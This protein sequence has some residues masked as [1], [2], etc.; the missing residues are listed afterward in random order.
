MAITNNFI[1]KWIK[2]VPNIESSLEERVKCYNNV[3]VMK[4]DNT[5]KEGMCVKT[6]GYNYS[7]DGGGSEF[8]VTLLDE[9]KIQ[10]PLN[11]G[12]Y[13]TK[14]IK[15]YCNIKEYGI[16][17]PENINKA[18]RHENLIIFNG[19]TI[20]LNQSPL[21]IDRPIELVGKLKINV[22]SWGYPAIVIG[23]SNLSIEKLDLNINAITSLRSKIEEG[24]GYYGS[25]G[26]AKVACSGI[27]FK[28]GAEI[29]NVTLRN[30]NVENFICGISSSS[31]RLKNI[32]FENIKFNGIDFGFLAGGLTNVKFKNIYSSNTTSYE[33]SVDPSHVIYVTGS[34]LL[35]SNKNIIIE[36]VRSEGCISKQT[37]T[38][39]SVKGCDGL[40]IK[41]VTG[42]NVSGAFSIVGSNGSVN[43]CRFTNATGGLS[44]QFANNLLIYDNIIIEGSTDKPLLKPFNYFTNNSKTL[45]RNCYFKIPQLNNGATRVNAD[46]KEEFTEYDMGDNNSIAYD[47]VESPTL[48]LDII[49]NQPIIKKGKILVKGLNKQSSRFIVNP[50]TLVKDDNFVVNNV[51]YVDTDYFDTYTENNYPFLRTC[52]KIKC[53]NCHIAYF[54]TNNYTNGNVFTVIN[55]DGNSTIVEGARIKTKKGSTL[56]SSE[57]KIFNFMMIDNVAYE[58]SHI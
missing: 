9:T 36:N 15:D 33:G 48:P 49:I 6:L 24:Q 37:D 18:L 25:S 50:S 58:I 41:N 56:L 40:T 10:I 39:I 12:L 51:T 30:I 7:N 42:D 23:T 13:A 21:L 38:V 46:Y 26:D 34:G 3:A 45:V 31:R 27:V 11:N 8:I 44:N 14:V 52:N 29:E 17:T 53:N 22:N 55:E 1:Q 16:L 4:D 5:L 28:N 20:E 2:K 47:I 19:E 57:W 35:Y 54:N 32:T 43:D